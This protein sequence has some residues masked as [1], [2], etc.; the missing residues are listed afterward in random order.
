MRLVYFHIDELARDAVTASALK[1]AFLLRGV[2]IVYG[3]RYSSRLLKYFIPMFDGIILP[4]P[5]FIE[6]LG[7]SDQR[8]TPV[9][10]LYTEAVGATSVS[11]E[12]TLYNTFHKEYME[13]D[14]K[15]Y[16]RV[17][18]FCLWG[19]AH[20]QVISKYFPEVLSKI[21]VVGHPRH[22]A[23]CHGQNI[24]NRSNKIK[25]GL[26]TRL[27]LLND[28]DSRHV[29]QALSLSTTHDYRTYFNNKSNGMF[30]NK[31]GKDQNISDLIYTEAVDAMIL[32]ELLSKI[33]FDRFEIYIKIHPRED[34]NQWISLF[35]KLKVQV[36]IVDWITPFFHWVKGMD[37]VVGPASTSFYDSIVAGIEPICT[38]KIVSKRSQH[39]VNNTDDENNILKYIYNPN[40]IEELLDYIGNK[41][42]SKYVASQE[43]KDILYL[44][45]DYP[46]SINALDNVVD[47]VIDSFSINQPNVIIQKIR[48]V[49]YSAVSYLSNILGV[50]VN[51]VVRKRKEQG[52]TFILTRR[53]IAFIDSLSLE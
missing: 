8:D 21:S 33:D 34:R 19:S 22:D 26:I 48:F 44:E 15:Y 28:F 38:N 53:A 18:K 6:Y 11:D 35:D 46:N 39:V 9:T 10:I 16:D 50:F 14:T 36:H 30:F 25:V 1:R 3:N 20:K 27:S 42:E 2:K 13:G 41:P 43:I 47:I 23:K 45:T 31:F 49:Q 7:D 52:S 17:Y 5:L 29:L 51:S 4:R 32:F 40:S 24:Y 12:L 37:Y